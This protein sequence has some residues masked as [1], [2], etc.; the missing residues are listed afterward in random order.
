VR[1]KGRKKKRERR[2]GTSFPSTSPSSP[3]V[4]AGAKVFKKERRKKK[5]GNAAN[6]NAL[7]QLSACSGARRP[8]GRKKGGKKRRG[9]E[10]LGH[11]SPVRS[12]RCAF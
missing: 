7:F 8:I 4:R 3:P 9:G 6:W 10:G 2:R 12:C 5:R 1:R 11:V